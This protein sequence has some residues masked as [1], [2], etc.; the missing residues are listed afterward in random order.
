[1]EGIIVI[2]LVL[3]IIPFVMERIK[4][5]NEK[6]EFIAEIFLLEM[7]L[8][9]G[10]HKINGVKRRIFNFGLKHKKPIIEEKLFEEL[11][12]IK[13]INVEVFKAAVILLEKEKIISQKN[14]KSIRLR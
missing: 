13:A 11:N 7:E 10:K 1:M 8:K 14:Y 9:Y 2:L 4:R 5:N 6:V 3:F 12:K